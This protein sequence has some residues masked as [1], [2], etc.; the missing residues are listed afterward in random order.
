MQYNIDTTKGENTVL[1]NEYIS[2]LCE[3]EHGSVD[4][5]YYDWRYQKC[6]MLATVGI[7]PK[8]ECDEYIGDEEDSS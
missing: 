4:C 5:P 8:N 6:N 1:K 7:H 2:K 3:C